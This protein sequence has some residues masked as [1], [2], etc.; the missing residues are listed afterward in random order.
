MTLLEEIQSKCS[1]ELIASRDDKAITAIVNTNRT[2][3]GDRR[4][5]AASILA[6]LPISGS[7]QGGVVLDK[8]EA[9]GTV[10][11]ACKWASRLLL[12]EIGINVGDP[13]TQAMLDSLAA[14]GVLT[15]AEA[16]ALK[17]MAIQP[18]L[19]TVA[20]VSKALNGDIE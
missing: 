17:A 12:T 10:I 14:N 16:N 11:P 2:K 15:A 7:V 13:N 6:E 1:A 19:V 4:I 3:L 8:I 5:T 18:S 20:E 9:A